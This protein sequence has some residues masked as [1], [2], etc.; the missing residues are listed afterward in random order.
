M[1]SVVTD[2]NALNVYCVLLE[3]H[4]A[5]YAMRYC[6]DPDFTDKDWRPVLPGDKIPVREARPASG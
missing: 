4:E 5:V 1:R 6:C 2:L 3:V